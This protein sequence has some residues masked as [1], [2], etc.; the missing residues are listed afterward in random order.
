MSGKK[1]SNPSPAVLKS[2]ESKIDELGH[3]NSIL[4]GMVKDT[5]D[6]VIKLRAQVE[7]LQSKR[8]LA[9]AMTPPTRTSIFEQQKLPIDDRKIT[10]K[11]Y[12]MDNVTPN[13]LEK[14]DPSYLIWIYEN[15]DRRVMSDELYQRIAPGRKLR[16]FPGDEG[17]EQKPATS[18]FS[19][20]FP[21]IHD[22]FADDDIP[23]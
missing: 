11:K 13:I 5:L 22:D 20:R 9:S 23:F 3:A 14:N 6:E 15:V 17:Y 16:V 12:A 7:A 18:S 8:D 19:E 10:F 2:I 1:N 21:P 4:A